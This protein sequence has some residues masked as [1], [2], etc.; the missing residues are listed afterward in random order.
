M[1]IHTFLMKSV[2]F[3]ERLIK[4]QEIQKSK[5]IE[6]C[7]RLKKMLHIIYFFK[8]PNILKT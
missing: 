3:F 1:T 7:C 2:T 5:K 8:N 4:F 6:K